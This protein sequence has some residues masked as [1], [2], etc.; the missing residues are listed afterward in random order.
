M[1]RLAGDIDPDLFSLREAAVLSCLSEDKVR[2]E[3]ERKVME[4]AVIE[5]VGAARRLLFDE[6]GIIYLSAS[7][8][9]PAGSNWRRKCARRR[10]S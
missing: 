4:P 9:S 5:A 7:I 2:R 8:A 1:G 6:P 10:A 3:V